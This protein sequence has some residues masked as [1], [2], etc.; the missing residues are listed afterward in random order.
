[1]PEEDDFKL[2]AA[3]AR[4]IEVDTPMLMPDAENSCLLEP[5]QESNAQEK[6][7]TSSPMRPGKIVGNY[8]LLSVLG[9]G[10]FS[11]VYKARHRLLGTLGAIKC[12]IPGTEL[13]ANVLMRFQREAQ[14]TAELQH[15]SIAGV[16]EFGIQ[17]AIPYLVLEFVD[18]TSLAE[19][20][21]VEKKLQPRRVVFL[22]Q[23][24][25]EA[26][27][28]AHKNNVV[29]RDIKPSNIMIYST[30]D[31]QESIKIIDF[32]IAKLLEDYQQNNLTKTGDI[33]G[34]PGYMSPEQCQGQ[35]VDIRSDVYALGCL[36]YEMLSGAPPFT[37]KRPIEVIV[38]HLN[39][40][41]KNLKPIKGL[42]GI[43]QVIDAALAK[44]P[45][46]RYQSCDEFLLD[47]NLIAEKK[48]PLGKPHPTGKFDTKRF[49]KTFS[50]LLAFFLSFYLWFLSAFQPV[51][52]IKSLTDSIAKEPSAS[53]YLNRARLYKNKGRPREAM[54][55]ATKSIEIQPNDYHARNFRAEVFNELKEFE[56]AK[57][58][59]TK[60]IAIAP[61]EYGGYLSRGTSFY[62]LG[63]YNEA[64]RDL[65]ESLALNHPTF[66]I[67]G[68]NRTICHYQ[69]ARAYYAT[70]RYDKALED[71]DQAIKLQFEMP[72][73]NDKG[74]RLLIERARLNLKL[75]RMYAAVAD[76]QAAVDIDPADRDA[77]QV[78]HQA[79]LLQMTLE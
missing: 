25:L 33:F 65:D 18:G 75:K 66:G 48:E 56:K 73:D 5:A 29:H 27:S 11:I 4:L 34:S 37:G 22:L 74:S 1:M 42:S 28:Y 7:S 38:K 40:R 46:N 35:K 20:I 10:G 53:N 72:A 13:D 76:A 57:E 39:Q 70:G 63:K 78:L 52:T 9:E 45:Q 24:I 61:E 21:K 36:A 16:R 31:G 3:P 2:I 15:P 26:L 32:G 6:L 59:A 30:K 55:D 47:I 49:L 44:D 23:Q 54:A 14:A 41:H 8:E 17:D 69:R 12:L 19:L 71:L 67:W 43:N 68:N 50:I 79:K 64:I 62:S 58:E 51:N 77:Q 60:A